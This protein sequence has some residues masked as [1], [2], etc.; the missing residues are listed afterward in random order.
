MARK[1]SVSQSERNREKK[2]AD[3]WYVHPN[4]RE[5]KS[6]WGG[7]VEFIGEMDV[8]S[9]GIRRTFEP[10]QFVIRVKH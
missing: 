8:P 9:E 10:L 4:T 2:W 1:V 7:S 5:K 6:A 3:T